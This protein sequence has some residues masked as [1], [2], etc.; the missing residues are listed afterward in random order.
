MTNVQRAW[1]AEEWRA[2]RPPHRDARPTRTPPTAPGCKRRA[3]R[4]SHQETASFAGGKERACVKGKEMS[5][6]PKVN[7]RLADMIRKEDPIVKYGD[8]V[9]REVSKPVAKIGED[10][11]EFVQRMG[12]IMRDANGVGLAAPQLGIAQR[13]IVYDIGEGFH[14]LINPKI[15]RA[16]GEQVDPPEGCLSLPGLRGIVK[17]ANEVVVKGLDEHGKPVR[18]RGEGY[19]ARVIQHEIDHLDGILFIDRADPK[20]LHW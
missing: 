15:L 4:P 14:A 8:P 13:V 11:A 20:S 17:R 1:L 19:T 10:M 3:R 2:G 9:L 18:I 16:K 12:E 5:Q 7:G 6:M